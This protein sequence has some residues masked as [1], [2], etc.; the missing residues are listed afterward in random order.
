MVRRYITDADTFGAWNTWSRLGST[1]LECP[2]PGQRFGA[3]AAAVTLLLGSRG[4]REVVAEE[5]QPSN[6]D[7][8]VDAVH[9][10]SG[11]RR[12][13]V[14]GAL[15][16]TG[17][18]PRQIERI[19]QRA[20]SAGRIVD[21]E[22]TLRVTEPDPVPE[23]DD[24]GE[25]R[26]VARS[27]R[28]PIRAVA[29]DVEALVR[30]VEHA[31]YVERRIWQVAAVRFGRDRA[32]VNEAPSFS[33][34]ITLPDDWTDGLRFGTAAAHA[35]T[36]QPPEQAWGAFAA[37][38]ATADVVVAHNG[39]GVDFG[40]VD[41]ACAAAGQPGLPGE[42]VDSMMLGLTA[43]PNADTHRLGDLV[44]HA[45]GTVDAAQTHDALYDARLAALLCHLIARRQRSDDPAW[46][47]LFDRVCNDSPGWELVA[48][49]AGRAP[50]VGQL[51]DAQ[52][53]ATL[54][55]RA[56]GVPV[57]RGRS[58]PG[59][60]TWSEPMRAGRAHVDVGALVQLVHGADA[61]PRPAQADMTDL[62]HQWA[63]AGEPGMI[64]APTGVG[65]SL[66]LLAAALDW[67]S[68]TPD[69]RVVIS[70]YTKALQSQLASDVQ[71]L[72]DRGVSDL[73]GCT[74]LIKGAG[75][76]LSVLGLQQ[77]L[78][79]A[80]GRRQGLDRHRERREVLLY[81]ASR[82]CADS[83]LAGRWESRSVDPVDVHAFWSDYTVGPDGR[84]R[85]PGWLAGLS[86]RAVGEL[87]SDPDDGL[88][89]RT[90]SVGEALAD[91][92]VVI[93]NHALL[94]ANRD[95]LSDWGDDLLLLVDE[96]HALENA[97]TDALAATVEY[98]AVERAV[99]AVN[100]FVSEA[101]RHPI[102]GDLSDRVRR[103]ERFL[104]ASVT[105]NMAAELFDQLAEGEAGARA[106]TIASVFTGL[107]GATNVR[108]FRGQI[109]RIARL[110]RAQRAFLAQWADEPAGLAAADRW[111]AGRWRAAVTEV[112]NLY[113]AAAEIIDACDRVFGAP[114]RT[115]G[116]TGA[117]AG[118]DVDEAD[119]DDADATDVLDAAGI[120]TGPTQ[121]PL[122][123]LDAIAPVRGGESAPDG[124]A[125]ETE[126]G[127]GDDD[128]ENLPPSP[129]DDED[130]TGGVTPPSTTRLD[131]LAVS[132][133]LVWINEDGLG[134][135][136]RPRTAR[137]SIT[138]TPIEL[139][140]DPVWQGFLRTHSSTVLVSATLRVGTGVPSPSGDTSGWEFFT[141]RLGIPPVWHRQ[142]LPSPFDHANQAELV[143]FDDF[144]SWSEHSTL[145]TRTVAH[146][147]A[148]WSAAV[149]TPD[150][151]GD[152]G[153]VEGQVFNGG[154]MVL[155]TSRAAAGGIV[156]ELAPR[157][158]ASGVPVWPASIHGNSRAVQLFADRG[159]FL[160]GTRGLWQGTDISDEERL[161]LVWINKL[162]FAP[163]LDPVVAARRAA[164]VD[165]A[166]RDGHAD[167]DLVATESYY[168]PLA[169]LDLR[170]A[171]GRLIRSN[172]HRG[173][174]VISDRKL[175]G[176]TTLR[177][178]YRRIFLGSLEEGL[179]V[180]DGDDI[181][182]G[183][184]TSGRDG[185]ERIWRF[186]A[187]GDVI[188][189]EAAD[190][191]CEPDRLAAHVTLPELA[192]I[193]RTRFTDDD[194]EEIRA[195]G[196]DGAVE[197]AVVDACE[198][199]GGVLSG[200][201]TFTLKPQQV[202][203]IGAVVAGKDLL[204]LL[205]TGFGKSYSFQLPALV[206]P[207]VTVV[208]SPLVALM[209][210]QAMN[211][212]GTIGASVRALTGP[213]PES[214]S[215]LGKTEVAQQLRGSVDHGIR[216]VYVSPERLADARFRTLL[217][218]AAASG[219]LRRLVIDEAHTL[220]EWGDDF[221]PS[222]RRFDRWLAGVRARTPTLGVSAFT[223]TA[224][225]Y[226]KERLRTRLFAVPAT[227]PVS[228]DDDDGLVTVFASPLRP[229]LA[230]WRRQLAR[231]G[232]ARV[233][234]L[235]EAVVD[236]LDS[237]A[238]LYATTV[239]EVERTYA[240]LR[241]FL[242]P[243][244]ESRLL[245]YHG[246]LS[247]AE[248]KAA[249][250]K[251]REAGTVDEEGVEPL[252]IVATS[253]FGLG[254]DRSDIRAVFVTTPPTDLSA[255]YQQLGRAGRAW[256]NQVPGIVDV[257]TC[258]AMALYTPRAMRTVQWMVTQDVDFSVLQHFAGRLLGLCAPGHVETFDA[259]EFADDWLQAAFDAG[260]ID[261]PA[262]MSAR[263]ATTYTGACM[264][265]FAALVAVGAIDDLG[266]VPDVIKVTAGDVV[267]DDPVWE[268]VRLEISAMPPAAQA[269]VKLTVLDAHF[270]D[271]VDGFAALC[272]TV[273]D[274]WAGLVGSFDEGWL[275]VSQQPTRNRLTVVMPRIST[276]P[277]TFGGEVTAKQARVVGELTQ[278]RAWWADTAC[279][280]HGFADYFDVVDGVP[281]GSCATPPVLCST[282]W[283]D[284]AKSASEERPALLKAFLT[285]NPQPISATA[286]GRAAM[287]RRLDDHV[288]DL[289]WQNFRGLSASM[290]TR[291]LR[292][293]DRYLHHASG[294]MR[295]LW[296][297]LLYH[298]SRGALPSV[299]VQEVSLSLDRLVANGMVVNV[300][301]NE[302]PRWR[303]VEHVEAEREQAERAAAADAASNALDGTEG[304]APDAEPAPDQAPAS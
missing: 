180:D 298:R 221:R 136:G 5:Q 130:P 250:R 82:F 149:T 203:A 133:T 213:M 32:W 285:P 101:A 169:A 265:A 11:L 42:R 79:D 38:V 23:A 123:G 210:D 64:E 167:P 232:N 249:A 255:L 261:Q 138:A 168:L 187:D 276:V 275:D 170:Q 72:I 67:V 272:P 204:A 91:A 262:R 81:L 163:F 293:E 10:A 224:N 97:A 113:G 158:A 29:I 294:Q 289:L 144:P 80:T 179:R 260:D 115:V 13:D 183:N 17:A 269:A 247:E 222:F 28:V 178:S 117:T 106:A 248:K 279:A 281:P 73:E 34:M 121:P 217:E 215:R 94:L 211:L 297:S 74:D 303:L 36:A 256:S 46:V 300:S 223:A 241:D 127:D 112:T 201:E 3:R 252:I 199:V 51:S 283:S 118:T 15:S 7:L 292:G 90:A 273:A 18:Q 295:T 99:A 70:T 304:T 132:N 44:V 278:L 235:V 209:V 251:F 151:T 206:L 147:L 238:I 156:S 236:A 266:D 30:P 219:I 220:I 164:I 125:E 259:A 280:H 12:P 48:D 27:G 288:V 2:D 162:P 65:K 86:Q 141:R 200:D 240:H 146:Q 161:R 302:Y 100:R 152:D 68:R 87:P 43:F 268:A 282:C 267:P 243:G 186:L 254:V 214:N 60:V 153:D 20:I 78:A 185:W 77:A 174:V 31:P 114:T 109:E 154:A 37:H 63:G 124:L 145:A 134:E 33:V 181:G 184:V 160:V 39:T 1:V 196:G 56:G 98:Q 93:A 216:L 9:A 66:A 177:R 225:P 212:G 50:S 92:R 296:P 291:V 264:R 171:I 202:D 190:E 62:L 75:N 55:A 270:R 107:Q 253:A 257:P 69:N 8:L 277:G 228:G 84:P 104:D 24:A 88:S 284:A 197:A 166:R 172:R 175:A 41:D 25:A 126:D 128:E 4:G 205:P 192:K 119:F 231:A 49:L 76:R 96:A 131:P 258:A 244:A 189:A 233:S 234:G 129:I 239:R 274:T 194:L 150:I 108:A 271:R 140:R 229:E 195:L 263:E 22:G 102:L 35:A 287:Q 110:L 137:F 135:P 290:M 89:Q 246:R 182:G 14:A 116:D 19:V 218:T 57:L 21:D 6:V 245:R 95:V 286:A 103:L 105:P 226:V 157:V 230:I 207:G 71:L 143:C 188:S 61:E 58:G 227:E 159:G 45:G 59:P 299:R 53:H 242:G 155:T 40:A 54:D 120:D 111:A 148:G 208:V 83:N 237:H 193:E 122:P 301:P 176:N 47:E 52:V 16:I 85:L 26:T 173:V 191:L 198:H 139:A 142:A 165:A